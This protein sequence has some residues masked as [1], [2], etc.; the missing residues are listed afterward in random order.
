MDEY[1]VDEQ[2]NILEPTSTDHLPRPGLMYRMLD[3]CEKQ[4]DLGYFENIHAISAS[5]TIEEWLHYVEMAYGR[6]LREDE[7]ARW[8]ALFKQFYADLNRRDHRINEGGFVMRFN[9]WIYARLQRQW[10]VRS[11]GKALN[12]EHQMTI[13]PDKYGD[14]FVRPAR[15]RTM[16]PPAVPSLLPFNTVS[17][18]LAVVV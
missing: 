1:G 12:S 4:L 8:R 6:T 10:Y 13:E 16:S 2:G 9:N 5:R 14:Y 7:Y 11:F 3:M 18:P 15:P 17:G